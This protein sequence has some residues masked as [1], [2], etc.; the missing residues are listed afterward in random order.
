MPKSQVLTAALEFARQ[1]NENS[2]DAVQSS[3]RALLFARQR[4][5][6]EDVVADHVRSPEG[7]RAMKGENLKVNN[8][9][10]PGP[11]Y[12]HYLLSP[13]QEGLNAFGDVRFPVVHGGHLTD[14]NMTEAQ[15]SME[16]SCKAVIPIGIAVSWTSTYVAM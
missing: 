12:I 7:R 5:D 9:S 16:E 13:F 11:S 15:T 10:Q 1:I 4:A 2:P 6:I 3:K 8:Y 14:P